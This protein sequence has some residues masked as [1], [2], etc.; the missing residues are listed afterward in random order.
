MKRQE[1][2]PF[3]RQTGFRK[4]LFHCIDLN[5]V[6]LI[7]LFW[8]FNNSQAQEMNHSIIELR[9]Q[10]YEI[11]ILR[12]VG[13]RLVHF[14]TPGGKNLLKSNPELWT[15]SENKRPEV[16]AFADWKTYNGHINWV[17]PQSEWW[18]HQDLNLKRK[19][20]QSNWPP[21]PYLIYGIYQI[22]SHSD[23]MLVLA[24]PESPVS[25]IQFIKTYILDKQSVY[26]SRQ[27]IHCQFY[28]RCL[29]FDSVCWSAKGINTL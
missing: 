18:S 1:N 28:G 17:G 16:N 29:F 24:S 5:I 7:F 27:T 20:D 9:N 26:L 8:F 2:N 10:F 14:S 12:D 3:R 4:I 6:Y 15:E 25:S 13:G 19:K 23:S 11:K 22:I 21:D